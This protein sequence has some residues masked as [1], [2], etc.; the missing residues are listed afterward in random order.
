MTKHLLWERA[1][2]Q[3]QK[4]SLKALKQGTAVFY[5]HQ[6]PARLEACRLLPPRVCKTGR[7]Y[8]PEKDA[9]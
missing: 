6:A 1:A 8:W 2:V 5:P 4:A 9:R 7:D 3:T